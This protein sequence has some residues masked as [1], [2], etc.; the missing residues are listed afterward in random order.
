MYS[1]RQIHGRDSWDRARRTPPQ[2]REI[3]RP[4]FGAVFIEQQ[5]KERRALGHG[6]RIVDVG[7]GH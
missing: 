7:D 5:M 2:A 6:S 1:L 4:G 3:A